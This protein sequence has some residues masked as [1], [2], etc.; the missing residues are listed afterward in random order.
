ML[1]LTTG[2]RNA[3]SFH[4]M[5]IHLKFVA[6]VFRLPSLRKYLFFLFQFEIIMQMNI[7]IMH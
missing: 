3:S 6:K 2:V 1:E 7:Q 4:Y 5:L